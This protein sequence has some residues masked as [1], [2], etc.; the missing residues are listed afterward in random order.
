MSRV[1]DLNELYQNAVKLLTQ[2]P[3][4]WTGLLTSAAKFYKL[5]FDK[6]VLVYM[7]RPE[8]GLIATMKDW[9]IRT[10]RYVNKYSKA[11]AVLDMSDPKA[12]LTYYF[13]FADTH[14]DLE[15]FQKTMELIWKVENQ[16][17][18]DL[19]ERFQKEYGV[20]GESI[21]EALVQMAIEHTEKKLV[22]YM[23]DFTVREPE[24]VLYGAPLEAVKDEFAAYVQNS[25]IYIIFKKC[26]LSTEIMG[27]DAFDHISHYGSLELFMQL[28]AC[29]TAIARTVLRQ[30]YQE[31]ESIKEERSRLYEQRS[32]N[33]SGIY[34]GRGRNAVSEFKHIERE[35]VRSDSGRKIRENLEGVHDGSPS[36]TGDR[37]NHARR[38][39]PDDNES[40][41]GSG[42]AERTADTEIIGESADA[43]EGRY[44]EPGGAHESFDDDRRRSDYSGSGVPDEINRI[45][46]RK[47]ARSDGEEDSSG[48]AFFV[49]RRYSDEEIRQ[50]YLNILT[51]TTLYPEALYKKIYEVMGSDASLIEKGR[52]IHELYQTYGN[53]E[54]GS[55]QTRVV[56]RDEAMLFYFGE[57]DF[58]QLTWNEVA[59]TIAGLIEEE[60]YVRLSQEESRDQP[61]AVENEA[62]AS[63]D[64]RTSKESYEPENIQQEPPDVAGQSASEIR[65]FERNGDSQL[66]L[67]SLGLIETNSDD[68]GGILEALDG[69]TGE[70]IADENTLEVPAPKESAET[71]EKAGKAGGERLTTEEPILEEPST[72]TP[73]SENPPIARANY[74]YSENHHYTMAVRKKS[75][76]TISKQ[77]A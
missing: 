62:D 54:D 50:F 17:K 44:D 11:I 66:S 31:I 25:A 58:T 3:Q 74:I 19:L 73:I 76:G 32:L 21:E 52:A 15:S 30:V 4:E 47:A 56:L 40:G 75:A 7:Q 14:G 12:K 64:I 16:Y 35:T 53:A 33:A 55:G 13:D 60:K 22:P 49:P 69:E 34:P 67:F 37:F 18:S 5:S 38:D 20:K 57:Y 41:R 10:G 63:G 29:S 59:A 2:N 26:G 65:D 23:K 27:E 8:A 71:G 6:N 68:V 43:G 28:G 72:E 39:Q 77:S 9:N 42:G 51:D 45:E 36:G 1:T 24:S 48:R 61:L 70:K 46:D